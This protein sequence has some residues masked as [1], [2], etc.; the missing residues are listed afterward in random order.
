MADEYSGG[1]GA[2]EVSRP[3]ILIAEDQSLIAI[4]LESLI[5][6]LGWIPVGPA[7]RLADALHLA[8]HAAL[9]AAI[10]DVNLQGEMSWEVATTLRERGIPF[11]FSSGYAGLKVFPPHLADARVLQKPFDA[12]LV[13][14]TLRTML[15]GK[16]R[17]MSGKFRV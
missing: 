14:T 12:K 15:A 8:R 9:D 1:T 10:L 17:E 13:V 3:A 11:L 2:T 4:A 5:E 6:D 16:D 7:G